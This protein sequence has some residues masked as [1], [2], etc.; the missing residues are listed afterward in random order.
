MSDKISSH[1]EFAQR[2]DQALARM[3]Q[4]VTE[5]PGDQALESVRLQLQGLKQWTRNG[6]KPE[7]AEKDRLNFGLLA[8]RYIHEFDSE[9]AGELYALASYVTY[10]E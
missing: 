4:V 10:W 5:I 1:V 3:D 2:L 7:Q 8:S 9:L 6:R